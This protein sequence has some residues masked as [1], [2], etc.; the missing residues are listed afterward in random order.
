MADVKFKFIG[1]DSDLRKKLANIALLQSEMS[2]RF[3]KNFT[4]TL[5]NGMA[6]AMKETASETSKAI[7][8][9][10]S[11][12]RI[13]SSSEIKNAKLAEI[14]SIKRLREERSK[15]ISDLNILKQIEQEHK[16]DLAEKKKSTESLVQE[17]RELNIEYKKGQLSL[18][19][20]NKSLK[21]A[22]ESRRKATEE[23]KKA[24]KILRDTEKARKD[25]ERESTKQTKE[26][27][28][29]KKLLAQ[30][31]SEYYKLNKALGNVRK[32]TKDLLAEMFRMERQGYKNT[33]GYQKL[34][35]KADALTKQTLLLDG[36]IKKIDYSLGIHHR[37]VGN[38]SE[39]LQIIS[40]E[41]DRINQRL[42]IFG[43]SLDELASKPGAIKEL[44]AAFVTMGKSVLAFLATPLGAT[45]AAL[46]TF[47]LLFQRN[48]QT[49]I[50]FDSGMKNVSKTTGMAGADLSMF[51]DAVL[52]LSMKL[53]VVD[54]SKLLEY[55]TAA[56][57]LGVRGRADI[58]AFT[59]AM[60]MLETASDIGGQEG[61][62]EIA[63]MLTLVDGG[64]QNV[65]SFGDEIVNL[66]NNFAATE[67]EI[68][69][70]AEAIAQN[71]GI[72]KMGRQQ[73]LAFATATKAV[74]LEAEVVGS[75]FSRTLGEFSKIIRSGKGV[76]DLLK[77]VGGTRVEL[78]KRFQDDATGV[79]IDYVKGLNNI[80]DA[81]GANGVNAALERTGVIAVRDQKVIASLASKGFDVLTDAIDKVTTA[82]GAMQA[83]FENGASKLENQTK[84]MG[85]AWDNFVLSIEKGEGLIS[86]A[87][88]SLMD[89][90]SILL[91][92]IN[93]T[94]NPTSMDEF[95]ARWTSFKGADVIRDIN[96]AMTEGTSTVTKLG[97]FDLSKANQGQIQEMLKETESSLKTVTAAY[98]EYKKQVESG[99]LKNNGKNSI[100]D[101]ESTLRILGS[102][103]NQLKRFSNPVGPIRP[104]EFDEETDKKAQAAADK[105]QRT[106]EKQAEQSRQAIE[107]QRALQLSID[108]LNESS[109][110]KQLSRDEEEIASIRDK[111]TK[112]REEVRKFYSDPKNKGLKVDT[113]GIQRSEKFEITEA[114]T[115]QGTVALLKELNDHKAIYDEYNNYVKQLG[116]QST[117]EMLGK[118]SELA[119]EY[120]DRI[121]KEYA[122]IISLQA[123]AAI[124]AFTGSTVKLTQ[125]QQERAKALKEILDGVTKD[126]QKSQ[127]DLIASLISYEGKRTAILE[128]HDADRAKLIADGKQK[129]AFELD[130]RT[131]DELNALDDANIQ[132][133]ESYKHLFEGIE[134]LSDSSARKVLQSAKDDL[135]KITN[136]S[137]ELRKKILE[138]IMETEKSID[139]RLP[140]RILRMSDGFSEMANAVGKVNEELGIMLQGVS[141]LLR[142]VTQIKTGFDDLQ[143][144]LKNFKEQKASG[145]GGILGSISAIAGV[146][147]PVGQIV[148]AVSSVVSGIVGFFKQ[149]RES[150][151]QATK[152]I[153]E[154]QASIKAGENEYNRLLRERAREQSNINDLTNKE[155]ETRKEMLKLQSGDSLSDFTK[156]LND[157]Q[158][159]GQQITGQK[160]EKYGGFL[161]IG[162]KIRV[163]DITA[164]LSGYTYDQ[165][166]QLYTSNKLT[167][168][169]RKQFEEL[170]K[171]KGEV[172]DIAQEWDNAQNAIVDRLSGG[173]TA[174]SITQSIIEGIKGGK[175]AFE[176]FGDD[177]ESIIQD[178]LLSGMAYQYLDEPI[179][180]LV[181][182]FR[183]DAADGLDANEIANFKK[184]YESIVKTGID[185]AKQAEDALGNT[186]GGDKDSSGV[187]GRIN[188]NITETTGSEILGFERARY[189]LAE[190][191]LSFSEQ[192]VGNQIKFLELAN[193]KLIALNA[194]QANTANTVQRLD[195]AVGH[196]AQIVK[197][198]GSSIGRTSEGMGL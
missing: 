15:E 128:K 74:G 78:S 13:A 96:K 83:E 16:S 159:G 154:Y 70:N 194:I 40:P 81:L 43:T 190:K 54:A 197:N 152:E 134:K 32:E 175:R 180:A 162:R 167:E 95:L 166:E 46:G 108:A 9:A 182:Q 29:R 133:L 75:T 131:S 148:G 68:L 62:S 119:K 99:G 195:T 24:E 1:D 63:R 106:A 109:T 35:E 123:T 121:K 98:Q 47:F 26:L 189:S 125:A 10:E 89:G 155:L 192:Q 64:V 61:A 102:Q 84:R 164:G 136:I 80:N 3:A 142:A 141:N 44:G 110:R 57:Q 23:E 12:N 72:Y 6:K 60:A 105:A 5:N 115:R 48:K 2:D 21:I 198:T 37:N 138:A 25:A 55:A 111:Y 17:E 113:S 129:E 4:K 140:E 146:A 124:G 56:G 150:A 184:G 58:L 36:G 191:Q 173:L 127:R 104:I 18:Q 77:I 27:E 147:G 52:D 107:R 51:G 91:D 49:V 87:V 137:P 116:V 161:G 66:G 126:E 176:D 88:L 187:K 118:Q 79:F 85:I 160:T 100:Q 183:K 185:L 8:E 33:V 41:L 171:L 90:F 53:K 169:T 92:Q 157:I 143:K 156:L 145:E 144:G 103:A 120:K 186:F 86:K 50:D 178:A 172:D 45:I 7:K 76:A 73:V 168:A 59:E 122:D 135:L 69:T 151:K 174:D 132:K 165:L 94:F 112:I 11:L 97:Q 193:N 158:G 188:A 42:S 65:K 170:Q 19:E 114:T 22:A 71:V 31:S 181:D 139:S 39:A 177:I 117:D 14:E 34:K 149:S 153:E 82:N 130:K 101:F 196:L 30:E 28:K 93:K 179:K 163:V 38:Y 20:Y 67:K